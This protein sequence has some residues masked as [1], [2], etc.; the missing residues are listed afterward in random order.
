MHKI[1]WKNTNKIQHKRCKNWTKYKYIDPR[2]H[3]Y[4]CN[5]HTEPTMPHPS[6]SPCHR[7]QATTT[8]NSNTCH[9]LRVTCIWIASD[10]D[11]HISVVDH[12]TTR[13]CIALSAHG[14]TR[15]TCKGSNGRIQIRSNTKDTRTGRN[16]NTSILI[17]TDMHATETMNQQWSPFFRTSPL[18]LLPLH[19]L[20]N[21]E[22]PPQGH[23]LCTR[24]CSWHGLSHK[25]SRPQDN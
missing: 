11:C 7:L 2:S 13:L 15:A 1:Q 17:A 3:R 19:R 12:K 25:C 20:E 5:R 24:R 9:P 8:N 4:A 18:Y 6:A 23:S 10:M 14:S 22:C 16:T 21:K